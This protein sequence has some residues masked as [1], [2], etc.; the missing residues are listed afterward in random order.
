MEQKGQCYRLSCAGLA[1]SQCVWSDCQH[2]T[3]SA[4]K[5]QMQNAGGSQDATARNKVPST[6]CLGRL[7]QGVG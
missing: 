4:G 1:E 2:G 6:L 5:E 3:L 7:G